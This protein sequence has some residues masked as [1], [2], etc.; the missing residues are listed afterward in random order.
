[1]RIAAETWQPWFLIEEKS[2]GSLEYSGVMWLVLEHLASVLNFSYAM[3]RPPDGKWG[4]KTD[5]GWNGMLGMLERDEADFALGPFSVTKARE[6]VC[7]F[8][9]PIMMDFW[10]ILMPVIVERNLWAIFSP[11][12][13]VTWFA[14]LLIIPIF[15]LALT[16]LLK[17]FYGKILLG[18]VIE[19]MFRSVTAEPLVWIPDKKIFEKI[20]S[21][22]FILMA[23]ILVTAYSGNLIAMLTA[24]NFPIPI[25]R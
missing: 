5:S 20:I 14:V 2:D 11:F 22:P 8:T 12:S 23:F 18:D 16:L 10:T 15:V 21:V 17:V 24:P 13:T 9:F 4:V 1:M 6:E 7:D 19:F 3:V 25:N